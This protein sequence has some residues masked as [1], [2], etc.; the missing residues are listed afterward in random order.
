MN[1]EE[2]EATKAI[3]E[4]TKLAKQDEK[5]TPEPTADEGGDIKEASE[6]ESEDSGGAGANDETP[7]KSTRSKTKT[8]KKGKKK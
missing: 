8:D 7:A 4:V 3:N 6:D 2:S 5:S 1:G